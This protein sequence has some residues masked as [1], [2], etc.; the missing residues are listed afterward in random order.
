[1]KTEVQEAQ[2]RIKH[3]KAFT[4]VEVLVTVAILGLVVAAGFR[5]VTL[6]LRTL[7]EV[8]LTRRLTAEAQKV[9]LDFLTEPD[10]PDKGERDGVQ[11]ETQNERTPVADGMELPYRR[12]TVTLE[13]RSMTLLLPTKN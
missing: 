8:R 6:S 9:Y 13:G 1:M 10:T 7:S 2:A 12:L 4:L 11:W 5:L 3:R